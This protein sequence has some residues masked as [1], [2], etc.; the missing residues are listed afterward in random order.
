MVASYQKL[1]EYEYKYHL[2]F[3]ND[4]NF[5]VSHTNGKKYSI[6]EDMM[7][8]ISNWCMHSIG[9]ERYV[10]EMIDRDFEGVEEYEKKTT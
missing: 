7:E 6:D 8:Y 9:G 5:V 3:E 2:V 4:G 10:Y 1:N